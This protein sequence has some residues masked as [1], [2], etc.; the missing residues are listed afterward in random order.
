LNSRNFDEVQIALLS[1]LVT[2]KFDD[3]AE[4]LNIEVIV[5]IND[6][7]CSEYVNGSNNELTN[8][9]Q[10]VVYGLILIPVKSK[11]IGVNINV[12]IINI[13]QLTFIKL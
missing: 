13:K 6:S 7:Q 1:K 9:C 2:L 12:V 4:L 8:K 5:D 3:V 11:S 10:L